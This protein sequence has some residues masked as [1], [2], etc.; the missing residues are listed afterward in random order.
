M[1]I[2]SEQSHAHFDW[3]FSSIPVVIFS[4]LTFNLSS[5][6]IVSWKFSWQWLS[7]L[8][9]SSSICF[10]SAIVPDREEQNEGA[11][12]NRQRWPHSFS[13]SWVHIEK[14]LCFGKFLVHVLS[15]FE[16]KEGNLV[17]GE[18]RGKPYMYVFA[19]IISVPLWMMILHLSKFTHLLG[20]ILSL[21]K[22]I[23]SESF[24]KSIIDFSFAETT[25]SFNSFTVDNVFDF[26]VIH[27][28]LVSSTLLIENLMFTL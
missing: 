23:E 8:C 2:F 6:T 28:D 13:D 19:S 21:L 12:T 4:A 3:L 16:I 15:E 24:S 11:D 7:S 1:C 20:E 27:V 17:V 5:A 26:S 22:T 10:R 9:I 14:S 18:V 25:P